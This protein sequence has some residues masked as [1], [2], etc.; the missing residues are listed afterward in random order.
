MIFCNIREN[1]FFQDGNVC[2][3]NGK[4]LQNRD[5]L[6]FWEDDGEIRIT[7]QNSKEITVLEMLI[8]ALGCVKKALC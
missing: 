5:F 7:L 1:Y 8:N 3:I 4:H 2:I 6:E